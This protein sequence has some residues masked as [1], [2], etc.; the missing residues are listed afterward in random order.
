MGRK[1]EV[2]IENI[3]QKE[4]KGLWVS[5]PQQQ[6]KVEELLEEMTGSKKGMEYLLSASDC[7]YFQVSE[8]EDIRLLNK[9]I[10]IIDTLNKEEQTILKG[11]CN[12]HEYGVVDLVEI[13]NAAL[14]IQDIEYLPYIRE[15]KELGEYLAKT[16]G[17]KRKI[18]NLMEKTLDVSVDYLDYERIGEDYV[19]QHPEAYFIKGMDRQIEG[20][21]L[22]DKNIDMALYKR[23][24]I[25]KL[26][27][28]ELVKGSTHQ[29]EMEQPMK[30]AMDVCMRQM[31]EKSFFPSHQNEWER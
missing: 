27:V 14:Q 30:N 25:M 15:Y 24:E 31:A 7:P 3:G 2:F 23:D 21:I 10:G 29:I 20:I 19:I 26:S 28:E 11:W 4:K 5:L 18:E 1:I 17:L 12:Q 16:T 22:N 9:T 8:Q 13:C 6:E